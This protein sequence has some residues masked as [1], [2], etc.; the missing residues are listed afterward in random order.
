MKTLTNKCY[1]EIYD[2][3]GD[4]DIKICRFVTAVTEEWIAK[5]ICRRYGSFKYE[6]RE[7]V[8]TEE[9]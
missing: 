1:Y 9:K 6:K 2:A 3:Y 8:A 5:D 4:D 7:V